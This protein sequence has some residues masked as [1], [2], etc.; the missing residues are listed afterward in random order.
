[1]WAL[2]D[3]DN[4]F[5]SCERVFRPDLEG[6]PL[7][8]LSN[9][10]GC[11]VARSKEAKKIGVRMGIPYYQ[12]LEQFPNS[13][14]TAFSSNYKLY[15][16]MSSRVMAAIREDVPVLHQYSIDE[17][18]LDLSGMDRFDLK[19]WG[20]KLAAKV[21]KWTGIPITIG[22][23]HT[24]TLAKMAARFGK[25]Y[26][27]YNKCCFIATDDQ[28]EKALKLF[29]TENV[30]GIGR[31]I[32]RKLEFYGVTTAYEF[33]CK[34]RSWIK[35]KFHVPGERIWLELRGNDVIPVDE[36]DGKK[37]QT[38]VTSRSFP[39]MIT[40]APQLEA[41]VANYAARCALKLRKQ[42]SVCAMVTLFLQSNF[43]REDL[44]QYS[45]SA[46]FVFTT[47]TNTTTEI[48]RAALCILSKIFK[49]GIHYKRAGVMVAD[50]SSARAIQ[51][52]LFEYNHELSK[53]YRT[54]SEAIDEIN[55]RLG[56][57]TV[58]LASQ[59]YADKDKATGKSV[60]FSHAIKL[61]LLSPDYSTSFE[62]FKIAP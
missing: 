2:V 27:A 36:M 32:A 55:R 34:S 61:A 54:I 31:R 5:C 4:F 42:G 15:A 48:V 12:M 53:K 13:G 17:A 29:P 10:D 51:P 59:Q 43:F 7:V 30:W 57:D 3:C 21:K 33:T 18:F 9:N 20:E 50:I 28:R 41:H 1:M 19:I 23:A 39:G 8:V 44:T 47:P 35:S 56:V 6:K 45:N 14:I 38:I 25:N 40:E 37:K 60:K 11:V 52:D 26:P 62:A 58:V 22:I 24:K 46:S 16:D 49:P